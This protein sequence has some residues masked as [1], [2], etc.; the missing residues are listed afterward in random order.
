MK[1]QKHSGLALLFVLLMSGSIAL[2]L[3]GRLLCTRSWKDYRLLRPECFLPDVIETVL[4]DEGLGQLYVC[5]NNANR[6]NV[7]DRAGRFLWSVGTPWLR[8]SEFELLNGELVIFQTEAYRYDAASGSFL[9]LSQAEDLPLAHDTWQADDPSKRR[10]GPYSYDS[11]QVYRQLENGTLETVVARPWWHLLFHF[12]LW[13]VLAALSAAG[14]GIC[15]LSERFRGYREAGNAGPRGFESPLAR[16]MRNYY[17]AQALAQGA[18]AAAIPL[19][20]CWLDW[21]MVLLIPLVLHFIISGWVLSNLR[22]RL[23]CERWE[24]AAVDFWHACAVATLLL[25]VLGVLLGTQIALS[26]A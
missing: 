13:W 1:R 11:N 14:L 21:A 10:A 15:R 23:V 24:R 25:A 17:R 9:G 20:A 6:V 2:G 8:N 3:L 16:R 18:A 12:G 26:R 22:D 7:Y 5:Y 19:L 4:W